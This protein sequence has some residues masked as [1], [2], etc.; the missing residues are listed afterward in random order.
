MTFH[1]LLLLTVL[2]A[3]A[4]WTPSA[5]VAWVSSFAVLLVGYLL[6]RRALLAV[7]MSVQ[8]YLRRRRA[9]LTTERLRAGSEAMAR[10]ETE[11]YA[12]RSCDGL[13]YF[14]RQRAQ[15]PVTRGAG[16][17][18]LRA[19][20]REQD[21]FWKLA[22]SV[23]TAEHIQRISERL[24]HVR[25]TFGETIDAT[26]PAPARHEPKPTSLSRAEQVAAM[27]QE[28][29]RAERLAKGDRRKHPHGWRVVELSR[30]VVA[31]LARWDPFAV[32]DAGFVD[33]WVDHGDAGGEWVTEPSNSEDAKRARLG[34]GVA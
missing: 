11:E 19:M 24:R 16:E 18:K 4:T 22:P 7:G 31:G 25:F 15:K 10:Y 8:R 32:S 5:A 30:G 23:V 6:A 13:T 17:A 27:K 34:L 20:R 9:R 2:L 26:G 29:L 12:K 33:K 3:L 28:I 14:E 21:L 1:A